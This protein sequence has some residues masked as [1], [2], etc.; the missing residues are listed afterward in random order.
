MIVI[1]TTLF[2]QQ[3]KKL[4]NN[5]IKILDDAIKDILKN[6]NLGEQKKGDLRN[7]RVYKFKM[8]NQ[9]CLLAYQAID[10]QIVLHALGS[11]EN[12]YR[13]LKRSVKN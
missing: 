11:H 2:G 7:I 5:Q 1:Q 6:P 4:Q 3:K 13:D 9:Q 10:S 8:L 12:F